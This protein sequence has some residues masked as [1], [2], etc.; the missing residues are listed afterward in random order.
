M[1]QARSY[2]V[3]WLAQQLTAALIAFVIMLPALTAARAEGSVDLQLVL[4]VDVSGS[5][6]QQRF[7]QQRQGYVQAFRD[8]RVHRAIQ[9]GAEQAIAVTM[10]QWTGPSFQV[11]AVP[12]MLVKDEASA[13]AFA[14]AI[15]TAP[16]QLFAG[17][18]SISGAIDH[19]RS[20]FA[21]APHRGRRLVIDVSGD[22]ANNRGRP[23]AQ[24]RDEAIEA[25]I[26][27]NGLPILA[28][29]P[30]LDEF[31]TNN[32]IGGPNSFIV[33][34]KTFDEFADAILKKLI[35]EIADLR[36]QPLNERLA[37]SRN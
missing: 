28:L 29:E 23:S 15:E 30:N 26:V 1:F 10:T 17:G 19:A 16:R 32:V 20:L 4:A 31:Y 35:T 7:E 25:G 6:N 33:P 2:S 14:A 11:I 34:A 21:Q 22:G 9:S 24:A 8:P 13:R 5:V 18:T 36:R 27:I 37:A 3:S 12:W